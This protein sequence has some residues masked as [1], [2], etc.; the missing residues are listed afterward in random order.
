MFDAFNQ[1]LNNYQISLGEIIEN[2]IF[3]MDRSG[4]LYD[5]SQDEAWLA[6]IFSRAILDRHGIDFENYKDFIFSGVIFC[7]DYH[8]KTRERK[9]KTTP[10]HKESV[11]K[12]HID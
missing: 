4:R 11:R 9:E 12:L 7:E 10:R 6:E 3:A 8:N 1:H 5:R 2:F